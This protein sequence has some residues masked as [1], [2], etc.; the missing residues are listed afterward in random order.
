[1]KDNRWSRRILIWSPEGR[2]VRGETDIKL[3]REI[4]RIMK[5]RN[6]T[7]DNALNRNYIDGIPVICGPQE[8]LINR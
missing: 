3:E 2:R 4:E 6:L 8:K 5:Q 1:M 7:S